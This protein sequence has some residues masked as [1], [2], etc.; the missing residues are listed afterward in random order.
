MRTR[1]ILTWNCPFQFTSSPP[2]VSLVL[3]KAE[4]IL[5]WAP[6]LLQLSMLAAGDRCSTMLAAAA[7]M[8]EPR[9]PSPCPPLFLKVLTST[10]ACVAF[11]VTARLHKGL[12]VGPCP[13]GSKEQNTW[14]FLCKQDLAGWSWRCLKQ[15]ERMKEGVGSEGFSLSII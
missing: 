2:P 4:W 12:Y 1:T 14:R 6:S 10:R 13:W 5:H 15:G 9:L 7:V 3:F 8:N 11:W